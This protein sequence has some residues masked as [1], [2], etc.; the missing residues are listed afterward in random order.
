MPAPK[1]AYVYLLRSESDPTKT[2]V[3]MTSDL[4]NRLEAHNAGKAKHTSKHYPWVLETYL[5][6]SDHEKALRFEKYLKSSSG[7][8]FSNKRLRG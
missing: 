5:A 2:Y 6:F 4:R 1:F 3:G 8:A 7:I